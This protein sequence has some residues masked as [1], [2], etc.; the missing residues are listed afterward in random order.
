MS[1]GLVWTAAFLFHAIV[2]TAAAVPEHGVG[3]RS[4][5]A[6]APARGQSIGLTVW[7]PTDAKGS[8]EMVGESRIFKGTPALWNAPP[9]DGRYPV[10]VMAHGGF[11]AAPYHEAWIAAA[12][13]ARGYVIGVMRPPALGPKDAR[14]AVPELWLR[15]ADLSATLTAIENDP[16]LAP[17]IMTGKAAVVGFFLGGTSAL[18]LAGARFDPDRYARSCDRPEAAVD[19]AWFAR[20]GVDLMAINA[21]TLSRSYRDERIK[22]VVAVDPELSTSFA[23]ESLAGIEVPVDIIN[24]GSPGTIPPALDA[25]GF[26]TLLPTSRYDTVPDA[27]SF[28][29]FNP[30]TPDGPAL[31]RDDGDDDAICRNGNRP[32]EEV[33][34]EIAARIA[35]ALHRNLSALP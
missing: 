9:A 26:R 24:L 1:R 33:H 5:T 27:T 21:A 25:S 18:V 32:R 3:V 28:S 8:S 23:P 19:C 31:L 34:H 30:C 35:D 17:R 10:I 22:A 29:A 20:G 16:D 11:R 4:L 13:A 2:G 6:A 15:P 14:K 7:Y 12:L